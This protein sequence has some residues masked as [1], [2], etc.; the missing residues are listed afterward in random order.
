MKK[1]CNKEKEEKEKAEQMNT[2]LHPNSSY[3]PYQSQQS[4][5]DSQGRISKCHT[6]SKI[7]SSEIIFSNSCEGKLSIMGSHQSDKRNMY[8]QNPA[9][10]QAS[11]MM[12]A[13]SPH[14]NPYLTPQ[15]RNIAAQQK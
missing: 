11:R 6:Y 10:S 13:S 4:G 5:F 7:F 1:V 15:N 14:S 12:P 2:Y 9:R 8:L 3:V